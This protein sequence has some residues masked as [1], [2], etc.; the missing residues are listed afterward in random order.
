MDSQG[1]RVEVGWE[2]QGRAGA[3]RRGAR[4]GGGGAIIQGAQRILKIIQILDIVSLIIN[5]SSESVRASYYSNRVAK[6][7][8]TMSSV[9]IFR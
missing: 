2:G 4:G 6:L 7:S 9:S 8:K 5:I 1:G 3:G